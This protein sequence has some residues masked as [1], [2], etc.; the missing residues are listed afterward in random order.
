MFSISRIHREN[1]RLT[2]CPAACRAT[3]L[4][5]IRHCPLIWN[6]VG[7]RQFY[8]DQGYQH[9]H[10]TDVCRVLVPVVVLF[11]CNKAGSQYLNTQEGL[12]RTF[13]YSK[14]ES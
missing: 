4:E 1:F 14:F 6:T 11:T 3:N 10:Y 12:N 8:A 7:Q 13:Q 9:G 5:L 2:A